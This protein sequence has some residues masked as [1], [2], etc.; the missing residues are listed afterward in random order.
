MIRP[1]NRLAKVSFSASA[2]MTAKA[3]KLA[4]EGAHVISLAQGEPDFSTPRH[5]I[6]AAYRA[7]LAGDTRYPAAP[8]SAALRKAIRAKFLRENGLDYAL[9]EILVSAG[10]KQ[11]IHS[12]FMATI[13]EGDEVILPAPYWVSYPDMIKLAGGVPVLVPCP[14]ERGFVLDPA[15]LEAA[16]TPRTRWV[17]LNFPNNPSGAACSQETMHEIAQILLRYPD[18]LVISD[19]MYEH[20]VYDGA[21]RTIA[22]VEPL[23]RDRVLTVNGVSKTYAMTGWRIGYAGGPRALIA[24]MNTMQSMSMIGV[25]TVAQAAAIAALEG[26]QDFLS[27]WK[28]IYRGRRNLMLQLLR[29]ASTLAYHKPDGAFYLY[30]DVSGCLGKTTP[31]GKRLDN[32]ADVAMA[33]LDEQHVA[34]VQGEAYGLSPFIRLSYATDDESLIEGCRRI[35]AFCNSLK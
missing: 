15:G 31:T 19:D 28:E 13:D 3:R 2:L 14:R 7:A 1:A 17:V 20:L 10:G 4:E 32:D 12:A 30:A 5:V 26:P 16:I 8:G 27:E 25:C 34:V 23:L 21:F 35:V 29:D 24:A 6:E 33:L 18:V 9:D 11:V 22:Q